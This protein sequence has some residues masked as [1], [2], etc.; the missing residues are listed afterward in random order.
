[1]KKKKF[2]FN[3]IKGMK[4]KKIHNPQDLKIKIE[5]RN[6]RKKNPDYV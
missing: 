1:M 6:W 3:N 2:N 4:A 5:K